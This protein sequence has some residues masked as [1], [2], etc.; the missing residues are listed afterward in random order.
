MTRQGNDKEQETKVGKEETR[1]YKQ[2]QTLALPHHVVYMQ[3]YIGAHVCTCVRAAHTR[4][5]YTH[6]RA[7]GART[8]APAFEQ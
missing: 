1:Q 5:T 6:V 8:Q 4:V 7:R 3:P 2:I